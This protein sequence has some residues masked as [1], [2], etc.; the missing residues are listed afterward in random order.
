MTKADLKKYLEDN[1]VPETL[2]SLDGGTDEE[3]ICLENV[4][5]RW[6]VYHVERGKQTNEKYFQS[7]EEAC[8][9]FFDKITFV[10]DLIKKKIN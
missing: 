8:N 2:Y 1:N 3:K 5:G 7:E 6:R 10:L 4:H 9:Y